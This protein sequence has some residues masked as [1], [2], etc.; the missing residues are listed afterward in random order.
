MK[1][2][3]VRNKSMLEL[4]RIDGPRKQQ[5]RAS[6]LLFPVITCMQGQA[7]QLMQSAL[8]EALAPIEAEVADLASKILPLGATE[9]VSYW[10]LS[11]NECV[12]RSSHEIRKP[13][14]K[15][16]CFASARVEFGS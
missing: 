7:H 3:D 12:S 10:P 15:R 11:I 1:H 13:W 2:K 9:K 16:P 6:Q 4:E 5:V 8:E 14:F